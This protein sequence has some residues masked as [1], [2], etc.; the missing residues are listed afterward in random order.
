LL[1][2]MKQKAPPKTGDTHGGT[3]LSAGSNRPNRALSR[4]ER[5]RTL[6]SDHLLSRLQHHSQPVAIY[7]LLSR[8][9][10]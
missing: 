7:H 10:C 6:K 5:R 8:R 4:H 2:T 9:H 3:F 1:P